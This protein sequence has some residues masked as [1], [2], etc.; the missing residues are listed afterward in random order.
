MPIATLFS[1]EVLT[2][3]GKAVSA[4]TSRVSVLGM[5]PSLTTML[6]EEIFGSVAFSPINEATTSFGS[7]RPVKLVF[8]AKGLMLACVI[9][10]LS[11]NECLSD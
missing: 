1:S 8:S 10:S 3:P 7:T 2:S 4:R 5:F 11:E 9:L 6:G